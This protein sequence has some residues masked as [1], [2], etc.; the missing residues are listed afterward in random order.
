M[1]FSKKHI[2][3]Y[4]YYSIFITVVSVMFYLIT[5]WNHCFYLCWLLSFVTDW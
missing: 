2:T 1:Y 5:V 4:Q 3:V